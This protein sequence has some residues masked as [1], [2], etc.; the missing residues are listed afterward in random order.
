MP[1]FTTD[2]LHRRFSKSN[3]CKY[4]GLATAAKPSTLLLDAA[5]F[6]KRHSH[7]HKSGQS[8]T[9]KAGWALLLLGDIHLNNMFET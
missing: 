9:I 7:T 8:I 1:G 6:G 5:F 2:S 4:I 3:S